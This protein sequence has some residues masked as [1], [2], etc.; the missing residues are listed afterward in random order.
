[1]NENC[2]FLNIW[3]KFNETDSKPVFFWIHGEYF[4]KK[5]KIYK[6]KILFIKLGGSLINGGNS[7][8]RLNGERIAQEQNVVV[9]NINYR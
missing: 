5:E 3:T 6:N 2:L 1:M 7:E 4:F 9:V 8:T